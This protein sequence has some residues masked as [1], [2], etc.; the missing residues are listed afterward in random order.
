MTEI[1]PWA[2]AVSSKAH[3]FDDAGNETTIDFRRMLKLVLDAGYHGHVNVEY[4]GD[5]LSEEE[6]IR[7]TIR[8]LE[9]VQEERA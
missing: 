7:A 5:K 4:E 8:L 1:M 2:K 6:G 3:D 9:H